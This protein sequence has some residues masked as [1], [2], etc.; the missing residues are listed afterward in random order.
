M[1][2]YWGSGVI[3]ARTLTS[4]LDDELHAPAALPREKDRSVP[5]GD[6]VAKRK[7]PCTRTPVVQPVA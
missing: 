1:K 7:D 2:T 4:A 3:A 6:A 5:F